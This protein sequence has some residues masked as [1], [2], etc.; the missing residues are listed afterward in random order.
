[1]S[2]AAVA[3]RIG[4]LGD[5]GARILGARQVHPALGGVVT[6]ELPMREG[7]Q[8]GVGQR[9]RVAQAFADALL[10]EAGRLGGKGREVERRSVGGIRGRG[11]GGGRGR[12]GW[13]RRARGSRRG[14]DSAGGVPLLGRQR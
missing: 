5:D 1:G 7:Q 10:L 6:P 14:R 3:V 9:V 8:R 12:A 11:E 2:Q 13:R 4:R